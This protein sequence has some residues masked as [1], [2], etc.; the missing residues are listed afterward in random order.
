MLLE[1]I[2]EHRD[3]F[4]TMW[5]QKAKESATQWQDEWVMTESELK[6]LL[7]FIEM[8][9]ESNCSD[10]LKLDE[11]D[12]QPVGMIREVELSE[13]DTVKVALSD[14][15]SLRFV[16]II[17]ISGGTQKQDDVCKI[18]PVCN[19]AVNTLIDESAV[20]VD[21]ET[22]LKILNFQVVQDIQLLTKF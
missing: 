9:T 1:W 18:I 20:K 11:N 5:Q 15:S 17:A 7:S 19:S 14:T 22:G 13:G 2:K 3:D 16:E 6:D 10:H 8:D 12:E 21:H 4:S